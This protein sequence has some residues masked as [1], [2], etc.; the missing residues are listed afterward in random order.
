LIPRTGRHH[1]KDRRPDRPHAQTKVAAIK[2]QLQVGNAWL[3]A[4]ERE[5]REL[6]MKTLAEL[7]KRAEHRTDR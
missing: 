2:R 1:D 6:S 4:I 5:Q 3:I 7:L